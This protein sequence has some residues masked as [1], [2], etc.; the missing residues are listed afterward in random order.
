MVRYAKFLLKEDSEDVIPFA[1]ATG[2][3]EQLVD[4][5]HRNGQYSEGILASQAACEDAFH[6]PHL[7]SKSKSTVEESVS[8]SQLQQHKE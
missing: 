2:N 8:N 4:H 7:L 1:M 5:F 3:A 6:H